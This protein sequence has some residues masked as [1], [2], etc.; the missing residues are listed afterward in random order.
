MTDRIYKERFFPHELLADANGAPILVGTFEFHAKRPGTAD[1]EELDC[2]WEEDVR[3]F[4]A[5]DDADED[6]PL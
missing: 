2:V 3:F 1:A 4:Q 6:W 5:A